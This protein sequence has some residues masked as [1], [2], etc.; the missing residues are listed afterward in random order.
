MY[1]T[2]AIVSFTAR[3]PRVHVELEANNAMVDLVNARVDVALRLSPALESSSLIA[4]RLAS[5]PK[6][7]CA[8][9]GYLRAHG[10]PR[11]PDDLRSHACLRFSQLSAEVEWRFREGR[12]AV[13]VPVSGP[14][15]SNNAAALRRAALSDAGVIVLPQFFLAQELTEGHLVPLLTE[16]PVL[17]LGLYAVYAK[18]KFVPTKVRKFVD[19]LSSTL[20]SVPGLTR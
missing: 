20:R 18:G 19:H 9:P 11:V 1:L 5:T 14:L 8:S 13:V 17:G 16:Y 2:D 4:R 10:T 3:Y 12:A 7:V 6:V 15:A